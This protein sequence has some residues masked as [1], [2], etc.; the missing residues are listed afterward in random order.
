[1]QQ[2]QPP[3]ATAP[4]ASASRDA[5][6]DR[7]KQRLS[8]RLPV[9]PNTNTKTKADE[10]CDQISPEYVSAVIQSLVQLNDSIPCSED[11]S[12]PDGVGL[13]KNIINKPLSHVLADCLYL[14]HLV[15]AGTTD[16]LKAP[17]DVQFRVVDSHLVV[18]KSSSPV[19]AYGHIQFGQIPNPQN[20]PREGTSFFMTEGTMG[21]S[22]FPAWHQS[23]NVSSTK[24]SDIFLV[25]VWESSKNTFLGRVSLSIKDA[26]DACK[27]SGDTAV[28]RW[29]TLDSNEGTPRTRVLLKYSITVKKSVPADLQPDLIAPLELQLIACHFDFAV[30]YKALMKACL[31]V[32]LG[33]IA[34]RSHSSGKASLL[35]PESLALL[36][37]WERRWFLNSAFRRQTVM[38]LK[39]IL[40]QEF[41][42]AVPLTTTGSSIS[43]SN[44]T[45]QIISQTSDSNPVIDLDLSAGTSKRHN[46][47][48]GSSSSKSGGL[49]EE[50]ESEL[51]SL[52]KSD[53]KGAP[54]QR[55]ADVVPN[56]NRKSAIRPALK[57]SSQESR[58]ENLAE[59]GKKRVAWSMY[60]QEAIEESRSDSD[61][62]YERRTKTVSKL[63]V[64]EKELIL[65][66]LDSAESTLERL[67]SPTSPS[68]SDQSI[69]ILQAP[70]NTELAEPLD[71]ELD[72][73][74]SSS[75]TCLND[76][77]ASIQ[78]SSP[79]PATRRPTKLS[80]FL[81]DEERLGVSG[82]LEFE[83]GT[84]LLSPPLSPST[85]NEQHVS[86]KQVDM[87]ETNNLQESLPSKKPGP[88]SMLI[89]SQHEFDGDVEDDSDTNSD[90][91]QLEIASTTVTSA[92][93]Q[94]SYG[95][96]V[97][98]SKELFGSD[99]EDG[100]DSDIYIPS[101]AKKP[102][103]MSMLLSSKHNFNS[104]SSSEESD[105][106]PKIIVPKKPSPIS[107]LL[108]SSRDEFVSSSDEAAEPSH[109]VPSPK[110]LGSEHSESMISPTTIP[111][112]QKKPSP[113]SMLLN[114][115]EDFSPV[116]REP[117]PP[118]PQQPKKPS[119][120][121]VLL[122]SKH[123]FS[124]S[125]ESESSAERQEHSPSSSQQPKKLSPMSMLLNSK[126]DFSDSESE[127]EANQKLEHNTQA[128]ADSPTSKKRT[129]ISMLL[130]AQE[131][132]DSDEEVA[133][134]AAPVPT[135]QTR[136]RRS[137]SRGPPKKRT[138][139]SLLLNSHVEFVSDSDDEG[140]LPLVI[141][142]V[143]TNN[144]TPRSPVSQLKEIPQAPVVPKK[145]VFSMLLENMNSEPETA[146]THEVNLPS[147]ASSCSDAVP[148]LAK[149]SSDID[150]API[151]IP[152]LDREDSLKRADYFANHQLLSSAESGIE[153]VIEYIPPTRADTNPALDTETQTLP[154]PPRMEAARMEPIPVTAPVREL[155]K[156][157]SLKLR[158][159]EN[160]PAAKPKIE[161]KSV[162]V[163]TPSSDTVFCSEFIQ[164]VAKAILSDHTEAPMENDF[165]GEHGLQEYERYINKPL[166]QVVADFIRIPETSD[167]STHVIGESISLSINLS[168]AKNL[169]LKDGA[170]R[171]VYCDIQFGPMESLDSR[172]SS[173]KVQP[174]MTDVVHQTGTPVWNYK[175]NLKTQSR[176]D[177][178]IVSVWDW[179]NN[180]FLGRTAV[181]VNDLIANKSSALWCALLPQ[182]K[183]HRGKFV[184]G[185]V[186]L[187]TKINGIQ[188][189]SQAIPNETTFIA[190]MNKLEWVQRL[191]D[192]KLRHQALFKILLRACLSVDSS[193][194]QFI[195][196]P[197]DVVPKV[198]LHSAESE[199]LLEKWQKRWHVTEGYR[200]VL[201]LEL[202][203]E[204][205][206]AKESPV[207]ALWTAYDVIREGLKRD[208]MWIT[209]EET[210]SLAYILNQ[211]YV[212][213]K[214]QVSNYKRN[215]VDN[216]PPQAL[217]V[218][219][220]HSFRTELTAT[221]LRFH[222][223]Q[224]FFLKPDVQDVQSLVENL[225][226][227]TSHVCED[228]VLD[229]KYYAI[230]FELELP[231]VK[232]TTGIH[233]KLF[234][235]V[236]QSFFDNPL[237]QDYNTSYA[238]LPTLILKR[239]PTYAN[240]QL[241]HWFSTT[242]ISCKDVLGSRMR[243]TL[244]YGDLYNH[245][246]SVAQFL[247]KT[248]EELDHIM[249]FEL[250][251]EVRLA[252][253]LNV[254]MEKFC[255]LQLGSIMMKMD[256][257]Q[258]LVRTK[259]QQGEIQ[260]DFNVWFGKCIKRVG[261][262][263]NS[264]L[265]EL[266][267]EMVAI[268]EYTVME[269]VKNE[270]AGWHPI[271]E[272]M[273]TEAVENS[274]VPL[275]QYFKQT[276]SSLSGLPFVHQLVKGLW[277]DLLSMIEHV[278][279]PALKVAM[280][281]NRRILNIR[282]MSVCNSSITVL[283]GLFKSFG[284]N[285]L[286]SIRVQQLT[287][288]MQ[289]YF[290]SESSIQLEYENSRQR[291]VE[292][293]YLLRLVRLRIEKQEDLL[294]VDRSR[295]QQWLVLQLNSPPPS[296]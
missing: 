108:Q 160:A 131:S 76:E 70:T 47:N 50:I 290:A 240:F 236:L 18:G 49:L 219:L 121:S 89:Q 117:S 260:D 263:Q 248:C 33:A 292:N 197:V 15:Y 245:S 78:S 230:P 177:V 1:M 142:P 176:A 12:S 110:I 98:K 139:I 64:T 181:S 162:H 132:F 192:T 118:P 7:I 167:E 156:R 282:Q 5:R 147:D 128:D 143:P 111:S 161:E 79:A 288:A 92:E 154:S 165:F 291:G 174:F 258:T 199:D 24:L 268:L 123:D 26:I 94:G 53:K 222:R 225:M 157:D 144:D 51:K 151:K 286:D 272:A 173:D 250:N 279:M 256:N 220:P 105:E 39:P 88:L 130:N 280:E 122:S 124:D 82:E 67:P 75:S 8:G 211:V 265:Q 183:R 10:P 224:S 209:A 185:E 204:R 171:D 37:V 35:T 166:Q 57:D 52:V 200:S 273:S 59:G 113:I 294:E 270:A 283:Y 90:S 190:A 267:E 107:M 14:K 95:M 223:L 20:P 87:Q 191:K 201:A 16:S 74:N 119:P 287:V 241:F 179:S 153:S 19:K 66:E 84:I 235:E 247:D 22:D 29:Y 243:Q 150:S 239:T 168:Q 276:F 116:E 30:M 208:A 289:L 164:T 221:T 127:Q 126:P 202:M 231:L 68:L 73:V 61:E 264:I 216:K 217:E 21:K 146:E 271:H 62:D 262:T 65:P 213:Y 81:M 32:N 31:L 114:K 281:T 17:I 194:S 226:K 159:K 184:G 71:D 43:T 58:D 86:S 25:S 3:H 101:T 238:G 186:L 137:T 106:E 187:E 163:D 41:K 145:S 214:A 253:M 136:R 55:E 54:K 96:L 232:I 46:N 38:E 244:H 229:H 182:G 274:L 210:K 133:E 93:P 9:P 259:T 138:P 148:S 284:V 234:V 102:S 6:S 249:S 295:A 104:D 158:E 11:F 45:K 255:D 141:E 27:D 188:E 261:K 60:F 206:K 40:V 115:M 99:S 34:K 237:V 100:N 63:I 4:P 91:N 85:P 134:Q 112:A 44:N 72:A 155:I 278:M 36:K 207:W 251:N 80:M 275:T 180:D 56:E 252:S 215:Y 97:H 109:A 203:F 218:S 2:Q 129:P 103:P 28:S 149:I 189:T 285:G 175:M 13:W 169:V 77:S 42:N 152:F 293:A 266:N 170:L 83:R 242:I 254:P 69:E 193:R 246:L 198:A 205:C 195:P 125:G 48:S 196:N 227:F 135:I 23:V 233:I 257:L 140:V 178:L 277:D 172:P 296:G 269:S 212:Y 228:I 120:M